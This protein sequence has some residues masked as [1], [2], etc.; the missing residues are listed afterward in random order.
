MAANNTSALHDAVKDTPHAA[1][2]TYVCSKCGHVNPATADFCIQCHN[3]LVYRCPK[4]WHAQ[5]HRGD[6][7][8]CGI[9]MAVF[10]EA[11][12]EHT[13]EQEDRLWWAK[14]WAYAGT[15]LQILLIPFAGPIGMLRSLVIRLGSKLLSRR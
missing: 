1:A 8:N 15:F 7:D 13:M 5:R 12:L 3:T 11:A 9:N 4:C 10:A 6:C 2:E 14:F